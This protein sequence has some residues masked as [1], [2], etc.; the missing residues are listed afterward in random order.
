MR[1]K[2]RRLDKTKNNDS[3]ALLSLIDAPSEDSKTSDVTLIEAADLEHNMSS[4][5]ATNTKAHLHVDTSI[6]PHTVE[7][8]RFYRGSDI[9]M[10]NLPYGVYQ[11]SVELD[12]EDGTLAYLRDL[13]SDLKINRDNITRYYTESLNSGRLETEERFTDAFKK[14]FLTIFA[15]NDYKYIV[16]G[17]YIAKYQTSAGG[18]TKKRSRKKEDSGKTQ[19]KKEGSGI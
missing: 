1:I 13:Y 9:Q 2:R 10:G 11:Y 19:S 14:K 16:Q 12:L 8:I 3:T 7:S 6:Y 4:L 15:S 18:K 17:K 5:S